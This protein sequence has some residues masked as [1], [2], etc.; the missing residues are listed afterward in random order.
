MG[1]RTIESRKDNG[2]L[3]VEINNPPANAYTHEMLRELDQQILDARFD[4]SIQVIVVTGKVK[5]FFSAG[6][7]L[8]ALETRSLQFKYNFALHGQE[9]IHRLRNTPKMVVAAINGHAMGGGLELAMAA[10]V[11]IAKRDGGRLGLTEANL[12]VMPG[13]GGSQMLP[14]LAGLAKG[15]ELCCL[16]KQISFEEAEE[17]ALVDR[18]FEKANYL[19]CVIEYAR[20]F[21]PRAHRFGRLKQASHYSVETSLAGGGVDE[22]ATT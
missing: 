1:T 18:I 13:M 6:G 2:L 15:L 19:D 10:D 22:W 21:I 20:Q 7:D 17:L 16:G 12:G 14:R 11:R 9:V 4:D 8:K 5:N 3:I